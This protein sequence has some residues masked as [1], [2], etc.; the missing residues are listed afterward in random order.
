MMSRPTNVLPEITVEEFRKRC[1]FSNAAV[2]D[3]YCNP[4][5]RAILLSLSDTQQSYLKRHPE[6]TPVTVAKWTWYA[7]LPATS[8]ASGLSSLVNFASPTQDE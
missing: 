8:A 6:V 1:F 2:D 7:N 4:G 3:I 5:W